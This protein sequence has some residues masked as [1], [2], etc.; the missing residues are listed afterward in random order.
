MLSQMQ[1]VPNPVGVAWTPQSIFSYLRSLGGVAEVFVVSGNA[2]CGCR[3]SDDGRVIDSGPA[4]SHFLASFELA[5]CDGGTLLICQHTDATRL[6]IGALVL[7]HGR[8]DAL[9]ADVARRALDPQPDGV[10]AE[11]VTLPGFE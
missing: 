5:L 9:P 3:F 4:R 2:S 1:S 6:R 10:D 11:F 8:G 7:H